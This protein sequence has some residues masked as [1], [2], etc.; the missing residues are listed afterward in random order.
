MT[1]TLKNKKN[2]IINIP[3]EREVKNTDTFKMLIYS[4]HNLIEETTE[5]PLVFLTNNRRW[6][7]FNVDLTGFDFENGQYHYILYRNNR[8]FFNGRLNII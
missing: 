5:I 4:E 6:E 8:Q 7:K 2:T 1:L 3:I